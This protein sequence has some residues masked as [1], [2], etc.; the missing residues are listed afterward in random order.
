MIRVLHLASGREWRGGERQVWFLMRE[1]ARHPVDQA[2]LTCRGSELASR[3]RAT[4]ARV[5]EVDWGMGLDPRAL[6]GIICERRASPALVHAHDGH[7]L[8]LALWS[9]ANPAV[10]TRRVRPRNG[11]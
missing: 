5:I 1:L 11:D 7:A 2:L 9:G 4:G 3:V 6:Y 8:R 10:A